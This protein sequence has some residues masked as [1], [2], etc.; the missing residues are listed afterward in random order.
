MMVSYDWLVHGFQQ[1]ANN[2]PKYGKM[3]CSQQSID[4]A[5]RNL[6][7][8]NMPT[9]CQQWKIWTNSEHITIIIIVDNTIIII[10]VRTY[11]IIIINNNHRTYSWRCVT[12]R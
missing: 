11:A 2:M 1:Y 7:V 9:I 5:S 3:N 12:A 6:Y 8:L 10:V 4:V